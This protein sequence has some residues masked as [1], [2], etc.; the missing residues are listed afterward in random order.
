MTFLLGFIF[1]YISS[2]K[3]N[4]RKNKQMGLHQT[5]KFLHSKGNHQKNEKTALSMPSAA[6]AHGPMKHLRHAAAPKNWI[7]DKLMG[8]FAPH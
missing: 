3:G 7:L 8:L 2:D 5:K 4:K 6:M 1:G